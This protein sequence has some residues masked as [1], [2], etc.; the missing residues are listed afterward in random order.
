M[1]DS[2]D[3]YDRRRRDKFR[4]E[5]SD[6][7]RSRERED[8][9]RDEWSDR[10]PSAREWDR[11]RERR[12]R[13]EYRDYERGRRERFSP[14]RHDM[15]PQQK[16]MRRDWD[17]HGGDPYHGG[18][19]LP[20][21]G[22]S[23]GPSYAPPQPWGPPDMHMM[24]QHHGI[25]IQARLGN[26]HDVELA[27]PPP[28]MKS[29][30]EFLL[31][32]DDSVD[33]T[34]AV[35][36]YNEYKMDFR[37]Q[38]MQDFFLAH[39]DEEWFRSKY[40]PDEAG[41]RKA[42][43]HSALQNRLSV[44]MY[45]LEGGWF[46]N[47]S[48]DIERAPA[49]IKILDAAVIKMEGGS[50]NDLRILE[51]PTE[52]EEERERAAAGGPGAEPPKREE[53]KAGN[54]DRKLAAD[55]EDKEDKEKGGAGGTDEK[56]KGGGGTGGGVA[57]E[58]KVDAAPEREEPSEPKKLSKKRKRKRSGDSEDEASASDSESDS[59]SDSISR[60]SEKPAERE[61]GEDKEEE[62][63]EEEE[64][65]EASAKEHKEQ[66]LKEKERVEK[67]AK[68]EAQVRPRPL[69][70]TCSLFMRSIAPSI[71]KAEIVAL[72]RR[73]PGFMRVA[74][75]E[76]QPERRFFRRC[77]V[78]FDR[79]VNIKEICWNLQN[80][81]LR[82]CELAPGVNRDLARRVRNINGITQH[83]QVLRNDIKLS[84]R[85]IHTLDDR[86]RLWGPR[87]RADAQGLELP[88]QNPILKN[89][90]DYLIEEVSAE[91]EELLGGTG[92]GEPE[93]GSKE[94]HPAE[95]TVERDEK[96]VKVLDRLLL[97]LRIVHSIDYYNSCEYPNEDEMPNRCGIVHV[98]GPIPPNRITHGEVAEWQKTFEEK[99]TPLFSVRETLSEEEAAKMGRKDPEQEVEK[100]VSANTQELGKDKWLCPLSGKKFKGPEF[101]RKH[102]LN[103]HGDK[104]EEVKKEVVFFNNFLMDAKRPSLPEMKPTPPPGPGQ[105]VLSPGLPFP[106]QAPQGLIGFGQ[107]RP[108]VLGYGGGPPYPPNQYG[109]GRGNYDNFRG[110]GGYPGKPRN[111]MIR[112]DPRNIIEYRDLDAPEDVDFF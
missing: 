9:R 84:A 55:K 34:E 35:K 78:T 14:P 82:D 75:S 27:P 98:R 12:S 11:G 57:E 69:H 58:D 26:I 112:G 85:L 110:Q 96:L 109:G 104:I 4:R 70:K 53:P 65:G 16:R 51:Q 67:A 22:G 77:W 7:D 97:Y 101:V 108:P 31:S 76:P 43:A 39:K 48:L 1:G 38:Q 5:R 105:G 29:F 61:E 99:L 71:S 111:R 79:S 66:Q 81:R 19:D 25:P 91:E 87:Q 36:R 40:H 100:F 56:Q 52:E 15:S 102:I 60:S 28:V 68:E 44:F 6:Y 89:I 64:E 106:P 42:D 107:P 45:L 74:L 62:E 20:Y 8:R 54:A 41:R 47:V 73:Y 18:Y 32:L 72:C 93:E 17:D 50:D 49:I 33:E 37:R 46:D 30:K 83:R 24:Q 95:I 90:T 92:G 80:I 13:A 23:G 63:D 2:D 86:E 88:A 59:D 21:G 103:K 94:G 3:E 10:R